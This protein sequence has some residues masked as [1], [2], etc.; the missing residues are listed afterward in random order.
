MIVRTGRISKLYHLN[1]HACNDKYGIILGS[2]FYL[3]QFVKNLKRICRQ[4]LGKK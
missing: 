4:I 1:L 3:K 2:I